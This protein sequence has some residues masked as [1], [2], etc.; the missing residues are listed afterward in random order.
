MITEMMNDTVV[1]TTTENAADLGFPAPNSLL[2]L[3]LLQPIHKYKHKYYCN[4]IYKKEKKENQQVLP[5][6]F[7]I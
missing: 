3:T 5:S 4:H 2:T 7:Q 1:T 6:L